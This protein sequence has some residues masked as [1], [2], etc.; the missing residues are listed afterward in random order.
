MDDT[1]NQNAV[2][3]ATPVVPTTPVSDEPVV[4]ETP[5]VVSEE[6]PAGAPTAPVGEEAKEE[7]PVTPVA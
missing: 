3:G 1:T 6:T 4:T 5:G 2:P 7:A